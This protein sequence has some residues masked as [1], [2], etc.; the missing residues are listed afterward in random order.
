MLCRSIE[1]QKYG[2]YPSC[3]ADSNSVRKHSVNSPKNVKVNSQTLSGDNMTNFH[4]WNR[5]VRLGMKKLF[6]ERC[7]HARYDYFTY[8]F[9]HLHSK[10]TIQGLYIQCTVHTWRARAGM[11]PLRPIRGSNSGTTRRSTSRD[12]FGSVFT[13]TG[14]QINNEIVCVELF[15]W[16]HTFKEERILR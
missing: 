16:Y 6:P 7:R 5:D 9:I 1:L 3:V 4:Y 11:S 14:E 2:A 13:C 12:S 15:F 8:N 10:Y